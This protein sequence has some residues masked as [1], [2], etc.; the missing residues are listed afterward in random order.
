[1][2]QS[3]FV[4]VETID[5]IVVAV[6]GDYQPKKSLIYDALMGS[7]VESGGQRI[8][9]MLNILDRAGYELFFTEAIGKKVVYRLK[10]KTK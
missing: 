9:E 2:A 3:V 8:N 6:E 7:A 4:S 1:M 10:Q 5:G